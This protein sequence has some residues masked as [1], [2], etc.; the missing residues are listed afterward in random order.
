MD[1]RYHQ[2]WDRENFSFHRT[3]PKPWIPFEDEPKRWTINWKI[4][5]YWLLSMF[6]LFGL[7][8]LVRWFPL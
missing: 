2:P 4:V 3:D 7:P 6:L 1:N 5:G 8:S